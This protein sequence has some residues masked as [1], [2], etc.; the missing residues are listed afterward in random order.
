PTDME[1]EI[2]K[3]L[4][5]TSPLVAFMAWVIWYQKDSNN[6]LMTAIKEIQNERLKAMDAH[7]KKLEARSD[8]CER[9]RIKLFEQHAL[10]FQKLGE[11]KHEGLS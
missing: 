4:V 3:V 1:T 2:F 6:A 9:D 8:Q 11:S 5:G 7:I 10:I